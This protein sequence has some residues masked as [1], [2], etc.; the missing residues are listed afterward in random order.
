MLR[1]V[2]AC[3]L[4]VSWVILSGLD[5]LEDLDLPIEVAVHS[6]LEGPLPNLGPGV[7]LV[8]NILESGD[9][10][11]L[12]HSELFKLAAIYLSGDAVLS[13]K[14]VFRLHKLHRVYL[15]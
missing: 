6:P 8:N 3:L 9:R 7:D 14:K 13:F 11:K 2:L 10:T 1:K 4:I 5:L 15:I 12:C